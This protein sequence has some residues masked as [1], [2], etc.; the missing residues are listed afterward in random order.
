MRLLFCLL[1]ACCGVA[2]ARGLAL[3]RPAPAL[4]ATFADG[5]AWSLAG[6]RGKVVIVNFWAT[7]CGPCRA[8]MPVLDAFYRAH[9]D[10][11]LE[12]VGIDLDDAEDAAEAAR[13]MS[14]FAYPSASIRD[15]RAKGYGRLWRL[16]LCFVVDR[17]G[18]LR[19]DG[20]EAAPVLDAAELETLVLPLLRTGS[21]SPATR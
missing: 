8:E 17:D 3:G 7:W 2:D 19:R 9:R 18:N 21:A 11:G 4:D 13:V 5:H 14:A 6:Q 20:F 15:V 10:E 16:P 1:L 12:V